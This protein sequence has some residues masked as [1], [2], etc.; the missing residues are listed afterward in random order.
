MKDF[1]KTLF[2]CL[3][4]L[5]VFVVGVVFLFVGFVA[6]VGGS[7]E[8]PVP[9]KA[10]LVVDLDMNLLDHAS[11][12]GLSDSLQTALQGEKSRTLALATAVA[13]VD[14]AAADERIVGLYITS[15]LT[16]AGYGSGPAALR[17]FRGALQRFKAKKPVLA[18]N[19][20]W[21][22]RD[23]YL[24]SVASPLMVNPAGEVE[25]NGLA[26]ETTFFGDA[27]QKFGVQVQVTRVGKYKSAVEP[28][29]LNRMSDPSREQMQVLLDDLWTE[30]KT[31]VAP[32]R[33]LTPEALQALADDKGMLLPDEAQAAGLV[34]R[35]ASFDEVLEEL[36][37]LSGTDSENKS[38]NQIDL[39]AYAGTEV[40]PG[41]G[42]N[43][44]AVVYAE[45]EIVNGEGRSDQ[46]GGD[47][48]SR[49][50]RK[51]RQ[52]PDVK[53]VVL[54][55]NSPGGSASASDLIQRE[56]ILT[57]KTKPLVVSMGTYAASGGYWI[58]TYADRIFAA[59]N[60]L[61][62]SIGV[63]GLLPNFQKLAND[64]GVTFDGVQTA[65]MATL[66]TVTR[67]QGEAELARIQALTDRVYEQFLDKVSEGRK[68]DREK[69][70]EIA[71][72]RVWSGVQAQKLGL[73]DEFGTLEDAARFAAEKAGVGK[74]YRMDMP[75]GRK[76]FAEQ[77]AESLNEEARPKARSAVDV[78][79][80]DVQRQVEVLRSLNDPAGVYARM[81]FEVSIH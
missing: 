79:M 39:A 62:G 32:D 60:T 42:K 57:Q 75:K 6:V 7:S 48:L 45:G 14:R 33:K 46:V 36:K 1:F 63:F 18:Y 5:G 76:S 23:Y 38:F 81:P 53:A 71:Q 34:D 55:V 58:S 21:A 59:P 66:G 67:P 12:P 9:P 41:K 68:L 20:N 49:E 74:D 17:E 64:L 28:F 19:V 61:T 22:K 54:R 3:V 78:L 8:P 13:A 77:L 24:A 26:S 31:T 47:R 30:W 65:R 72:G 40:H 51:L 11:A 29:L 4:A 69:L 43:R 16:P 70:K 35:V 25:M 73:V 2:A 56:V 44:I 37:K 80:A 10:V 52:D 50:L 27:L 15:N